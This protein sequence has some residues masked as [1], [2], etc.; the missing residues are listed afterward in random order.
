MQH[1]MPT[2]TIVVW[3][4]RYANTR[5]ILSSYAETRRD[6]AQLPQVLQPYRNVFRPE[7]FDDSTDS[8]RPGK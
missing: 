4:K 3:D 2:L 7:Q 8:L 6:K 1:M 5:Y